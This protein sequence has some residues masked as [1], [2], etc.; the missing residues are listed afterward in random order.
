MDVTAEEAGEL[1][2]GGSLEVPP[3]LVT[4]LYKRGDDL[5]QDQLVVQL[6]SLMDRWGCGWAGQRS[7]STRAPRAVPRRRVQ[8][9]CLP[10]RRT[11]RLLKREHLDLRITPYQVLATSTSDGLI[12]F[13]P[14]TPLARVLAECRSI[15]RYLAMHHPDP[16]GAH[17]A[18]RT[19]PPC[20]AERLRGPPL[21][22]PRARFTSR[23]P[24]AAP[25]SPPARRPL[26]P[27]RRRA[28]HVCAL[29]CWVLRDDLHPGGGRP[30]PGQ[31]AARSRRP[32][33][34]RRLWVHP[35]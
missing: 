1:T 12:E 14:S 35:G 24:L 13:V 21:P 17:F 15:H 25:P 16:A 3:T 30:P 18:P 19:L 29:V 23:R 8:P 10:P 34:P 28:C 7:P 6:I 2:P 20:R 27:A 26:W 33:V 5:R 32:V 31:P 11:L 9:P 22:P 4:L